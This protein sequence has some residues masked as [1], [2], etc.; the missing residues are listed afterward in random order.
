MTTN[1]TPD[2]NS[3]RPKTKKTKKPQGPIRWNAI[4][5]LLVFFLLNF[6]YFHFFFDGHMKSL[7]E[8]SGYKALGAEVNVTEFK[9]SFTNG[10]VELNKIE[11][12]NKEQPQFNSI[13]LSRVQFD[14]S[15]DALLRLKFVIENIAVEGVQFQSKRASPGKVAPPEPVV[16][17][18][19]SFTAQLQKNALGKLEKDNKSN[20]IGDIA[21]FLKNGDINSQ[22]KGFEDQIASKKMAEELNI[23]WAQKQKEWDQNIKTLPKES[24]FNGLKERFS[25]IKYKDF[26]SLDEV[27]N[28]VNEFNSLKKDVDVKVQAIKE[29][30]SKLT[31]DVAAIQ[32]DYK[33]LEKQ[34]KD[35]VDIVKSKFKIPKLDA[36]S[37]AKSLFMN[38][39]TPYAQKLDRFKDMA[40][41]Y[42]PPK[43]SKM[44]TSKLD[45]VENKLK[46]KKT[47]AVATKDEDIDDTIQPHP[48]SKGVSYEFPITTG[49]PLFWIKNISIS[50]KSNASVDYGDIAGTITNI[51]SN[52]RQ[53]NKQTELKLTGDFN[54]QNIHGIRAFAA[55]NNLK[56]S[57]EVTFNF[58]VGSYPLANLALID[59]PDAGIKIPASKNTLSVQGKTIGFK[60][61]DLK[62][63]N[64]FK[65][66]K[67]DITAK[68][69]TI[70]DILIGTFATIPNFDVTAT[71]RG[72]LSDLAM[73]INSTL[74]A[75]LEA[76]FN[77]LLQKKLD[78]VN[79]LVKEK[80]DQ[81]IAKQKEQLNSQ[82]AKLSGGYLTDINQ[83][84]SKLD[85]QKKLADE[86]INA[87]KKDLENKAKGKVEEEG[88]KAIDDLKKKFGF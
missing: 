68:D 63:K 21:L 33:N 12:T 60:N 83:A 25:K 64:E 57:P 79:K 67:F 86:R 3:S 51:T 2:N 48:R 36:G 22:L 82:V 32:A 42:L 61:Y 85:D 10:N 23:K 26:K 14:L 45:K 35:D 24:E 28:S 1:Q 47:T 58:D 30:K 73:D 71:A 56:A 88:K 53:I 31:T 6:I 41:K 34:I 50:S 49:Y 75:K 87:S 43:Y 76:A 40:E 54:S 44:V 15:I 84:Q 39:L 8:W 74:G 55:F 52:Q 17:N 16:E 66:V 19:P 13:E 65:D 77:G 18:G 46:G 69:K 62:M 9:S 59:S 11:L 37:F 80:I 4:V 29:T 38:Y 81:E 7:I 78:E 72:D 27:N 5:P 70:S 20:I